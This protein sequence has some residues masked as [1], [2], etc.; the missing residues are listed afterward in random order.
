MTV[1]EDVLV[2]LRLDVDLIYALVCV[3]CINL[4]LI[5]K[6]ADVADY[7][8]ILHLLH[9]FNSDDVTVA[10]CS[11]EYIAFTEGLLHGFHLEAFHCSLQCTYRINLGHNDPGSV[12]SH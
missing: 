10:G 7:C 4:Y 5:V 6:V 1:G 3:K 8:L 12:R 2:N 9:M 11:H